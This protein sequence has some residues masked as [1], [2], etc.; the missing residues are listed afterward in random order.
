MTK[1]LIILL[2]FLCIP[3]FI[4]AQSTSTITG[5]VRDKKETLP[6]AAV[7]VSGYKIATLTNNDGKFSLPKLSPGNYDIL[8]QMIGYL[9]YSKNVIIS[10]KP[11]TL[12]ITLQENVNLLK[13]V[14][15]KPDPNRAYYIALF[16]DFFIGKTPNAA[17]CKILNTDALII[18]D[19]KTQSLLT[20]KASD[21]LIIENKALGYKLRYLLEYFEYDYNIKMVF[22]AGHPHF[23][24]MKG[25][26]AKQKKWLKNRAIAYNGSSEHFFK[27]LYDNTITQEGFVINKISKIPNKNRPADSLIN[28]KIK[29]L[30]TGKNGLTNVLTFN[31]SDSLSYWLKQRKE[32]KEF[33]V[34][35]RKDVLVDTLVSKFNDDL[36]TIKYNNELY[37]IYKNEK[38]TSVF[39]SSGLKQNRPMDL[40]D[41]QISVLKLLNPSVNFYGNGAVADPRALLYKGFWAYEKVADMVPMDY[42]KNNNNKE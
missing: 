8:I 4:H 36:K 41:F 35:S 5:T 18:D 32:P 33:S 39:N 13:E 11:V 27:S 20:V 17:D 25:S 40:N 28:A 38:E 9:P 21:F 12:N 29:Q 7:Y 3:P 14:V 16:K 23:E 10:D 24:E 19:D 26:G 34:V 1:K 31:G 30:T 15:I 22:Y 37:V 2:L 6:G 42:L